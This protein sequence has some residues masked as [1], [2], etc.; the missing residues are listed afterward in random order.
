MPASTGTELAPIEAA[1]AA[2]P[3]A[4]RRFCQSI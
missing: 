3:I 4:K 2:A 1:A